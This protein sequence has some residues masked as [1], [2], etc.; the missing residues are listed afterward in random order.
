MKKAGFRAPKKRTMKQHQK[1][2]DFI[3]QA[4]KNSEEPDW[5]GPV[6][7]KAKFSV[8]LNKA[9]KQWLDNYCNRTGQARNRAIRN[10]IKKEAGV[11]E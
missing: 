2:D 7:Q 9:E 4:D 11:I 8:T 5:N 6:D 10:L 1:I 3:N